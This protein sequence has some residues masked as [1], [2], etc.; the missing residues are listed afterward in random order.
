MRLWV[1]LYVGCVATVVACVHTQLERSGVLRQA[2]RDEQQGF[3]RASFGLG[4]FPHNYNHPKL[5]PIS[6]A[7]FPTQRSQIQETENKRVHC[8]TSQTLL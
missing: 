8:S 6:T 3:I 1:V 4:M 7:G 2:S 5:Q